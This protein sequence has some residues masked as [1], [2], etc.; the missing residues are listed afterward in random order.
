MASNGS[1]AI[2]ISAVDG[3]S[4]TIDGINRRIAAMQA[5]AERMSKSL[6]RFGEVSGVARLSQGMKSLGAESFGVF[7][8]MERIVAPLSA[9]GG[10]ASIA[11]VVE[12]EKKFGALGNRIGNLSYR[13]N[14]TPEHLAKL[15]GAARLAGVS[16]EAMDAGLGALDERLRGATFGRD[17]EAVQMF[18]QLH[19]SFKNADGSARS[20]ADAIADIAAA[21]QKLPTAG[22]KARAIQTLLGGDTLLPL[23][24]DGGAALK[25][26][27]EEAGK[28]NPWTEA[29]AARAAALNHSFAEVGESISGVANTIADKLAPETTKMAE[30][31]AAWTSANRELIGTKIGGWVEGFVTELEK[32]SAWA[33]RHP[34]LSAF[35]LGA[36]AGYRVGGPLGAL[37]FGA[38]AS[39]DAG[40]GSANIGETQEQLDSHWWNRLIPDFVRKHIGGGARSSGPPA[41]GS[42]AAGVAQQAHDYFRGLGYTE[43]QT[44]GVLARINRESGFA[45]NAV[46][47]DGTSYGLFQYHA[48]RLA[49]IRARYGTATPTAAQQLEYA[50]WE[51]S[52]GPEAATGAALRGAKTAEQAGMVFTSGFERPSDTAGESMRTGADAGAYVGRY[53][54]AQN[55]HVQVDVHIKGAPAGTTATA[56]SSGAVAVGA[57]KVASPSFGY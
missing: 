26:F 30:H 29:M 27:T 18:N 57:P 39:A 32:V 36:A 14:A 17:P 6:N 15:E 9:I 2:N 49:A 40:P 20:A 28:L 38:A 47:D 55:G 41:A 43:E 51:L 22:A 37:G 31:I 46:G 3:A 33:D 10:A 4:K 35:I 48:A 56:A 53:A 23:L 7:R 24:K 42:P 34:Q 1:F 50:G 13:L 5:P 44:A 52:Q 12:L 16:T 11:G 25:Q 19:V 8:S 54:P 21:I 45:P